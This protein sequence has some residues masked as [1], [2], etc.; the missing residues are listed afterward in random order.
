MIIVFTESFELRE[1]NGYN[2]RYIKGVSGSHN[3]PMY[4]AEGFADAG[5]RVYFVSITNAMEPREYNGVVYCNFDDFQDLE[6]CDLIVATNN[7]RD[8]KILKKIGNYKRLAFIMHNELFNNDPQFMHMFGPFYRIADDRL[9]MIYLSQNGK[10]NIL[11]MQNFLFPCQNAILPNCLNLKEIIPFQVEKKENAFVFFPVIE[12]GYGMVRDLLNHFPDFKLIT[13]TYDTNNLKFINPNH[14]IEFTENSS[15]LKV[16][17]ALSRSK[18]FVYSLVNYEKIHPHY[19]KGSIH[20]D[21]FGYVVIEAFLHGV[22][23][24]AP[25]M[26]VFE[27]IFGDAIC[28]IDTEDIIPKHFMSKWKQRNENF[29]KPILNRYVDKIQFLEDHPEVRQQYIEKGLE[30]GKQ[31]CHKKVAKRYLDALFPVSPAVST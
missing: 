13:N 2:A 8:L 18:Y 9:A 23:V 29:G 30:V 27:Q 12:R 17:H 24:I 20:Y 28:Y 6:Y 1:W 11:N 16:Y 22:I 10:D 3:G 25:K 4:L 26:E 21:T 14:Q 31:F 15:K 19:D 7:I 5:H